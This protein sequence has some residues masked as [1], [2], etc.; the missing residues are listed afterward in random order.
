MSS[1]RLSFE[2]VSGRR[3][4]RTS[5][6]EAAKRVEIENYSALSADLTTV[7]TVKR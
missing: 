7:T 2:S 6:D 3:N 4:V 1:A 5:W